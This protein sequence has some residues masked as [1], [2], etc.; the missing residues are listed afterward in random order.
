VY[1]CVGASVVLSGELSLKSQLHPVIAPDEIDEVFKKDVVCPRHSG[2][3]V[4]TA[5]GLGFT[6]IE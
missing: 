5:F 2:E 1:V 3:A 4:Y 6:T